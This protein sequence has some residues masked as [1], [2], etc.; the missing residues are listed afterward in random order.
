M[1]SRIRHVAVYT[2][3]Y[4]QTS[5]FYQTIFGMKKITTGMTDEKGNYDPNRGHISDGVIGLALLQR[6]AGIRSGFGAVTK[7][8]IDSCML[9]QRSLADPDGVLMD[10]VK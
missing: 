6:H 7:R 2:E 10:L 9:G 3:N 4:Q 5:R 1:F 8:E